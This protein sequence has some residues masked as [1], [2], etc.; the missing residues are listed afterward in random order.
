M[1]KRLIFDFFP[2]SHDFLFHCFPF[3]YSVN[4]QTLLHIENMPFGN[5]IWEHLIVYICDKYIVLVFAILQNFLEEEKK[6]NKLNRTNYNFFYHFYY[7]K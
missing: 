7:Q 4:K 1:R 5:S 2:Q 3:R 6:T